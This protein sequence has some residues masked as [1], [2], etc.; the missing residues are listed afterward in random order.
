MRTLCIIMQTSAA[1]KSLCVGTRTPAE[2]IRCVKTPGKPTRTS[3]VTRASSWVPVDLSKNVQRAGATPRRIPIHG[4]GLAVWWA[5]N[6]AVAVDD[7]C[8]H[9]GASLSA[10]G[11]VKDDCVNCKY[12]GQP[13]RG[14]PLVEEDGI[15]WRFY[16]AAAPP[17]DEPVPPRPEDFLETG[18]RTFS[19]SRKFSGCNPLLVIENVTDEAHLLGGTVH[20]FHSV[21][22]DPKVTIIRGGHHGKATYEYTSKTI[23]NLTI[24]NEFIG[25]WTALLRFI[26]NGQHGFTI[27]FNVVPHGVTESTLLVRVNRSDHVSLGA[28]GD[29][30]YLAVNELPLWEDRHI[31]RNTDWTRWSQNKLTRRD[32]FLK[33]YRAY[34][35]ESHPDIV[36]MYTK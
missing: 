8:S 27:M 1:A 26:F 16:G 4:D 6:G 25:P 36:E 20:R 12:H 22:G 32:A 24:E 7:A 9:R 34:L 29:L 23:G 11:T 17:E 10:G 33:L 31:V 14:I 3:G 18:R 2:F 15:L 13:A 28:L 19:Y 30:M 21:D 5:P 35:T